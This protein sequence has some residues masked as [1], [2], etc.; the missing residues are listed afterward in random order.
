MSYALIAI[1]A[2]LASGLTFFSGFG[3]G[4]LLMPAFAVFVPVSVAVGA[5]AVVHLANNLFKLWL[6][7]RHADKRVL[8]A[9]APAAIVS[10]IIGAALLGWLATALPD[11]GVLHRYS[12]GSREC[13]ITIVKLVIAAIIAGFAVVELHPK[14]DALAFDRKWLWLGG[15]ISGLF[16]GLSGHQGALR[17]A[18]LIRCGLSKD[19]FVATG[20]VAAVLVD[21][22]RL[23]VY[24]LFALGVVGAGTHVTNYVGIVSQ[25]RD[26]GVAGLVAIGCVAALAGSLIGQRLV[27]KMTLR[28]L[29]KVVGA[30]L[31]AFA[32]ALGSG[33]V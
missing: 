33:L 21:C 14:F 11:G 17:S 20:V 1:V 12:L 30:A 26:S 31:L 2:L 13:A 29:R 10:A 27:K 25:L 8:M 15:A 19:A 32:L 4:T 24:A 7:G 6:V 22:S 23:V 3:L 28:G 18:F 16:G 5:T 9:F